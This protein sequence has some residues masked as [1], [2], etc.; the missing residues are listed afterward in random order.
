MTARP[1][2]WKPGASDPLPHPRQLALGYVFAPVADLLGSAI[3]L[4]VSKVDVRAVPVSHVL[5][6]AAR[7][8]L[9]LHALSDQARVF[10]VFLRNGQVVIGPKN[11]RHLRDGNLPVLSRLSYR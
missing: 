6:A 10:A 5:S 3:E 2:C 8:L 11:P 7:W 1:G 9:A 4:L